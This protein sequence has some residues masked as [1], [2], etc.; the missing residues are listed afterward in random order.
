VSPSRTK[1]KAGSEERERAED[2]RVVDRRRRDDSRADGL[3]HRHPENE[4]GDEVEEGSPDHGLQGGENA[5][6]YDRRD[7]VGG[8]VEPV[9][10]VEDQGDDHYGGDE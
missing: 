1:A 2:H 7:R 6:G 4:E 8:V 3:R 9:E 10:E 5:G